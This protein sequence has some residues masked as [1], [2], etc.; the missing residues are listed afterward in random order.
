MA[1]RININEQRLLDWH[2]AQK[3]DIYLR[4][5]HPDSIGTNIPHY[6][7]T[8][9]EAA[10]MAMYDAMGNALAKDL[11]EGRSVGYKCGVH[12]RDP[13]FCNGLPRRPRGR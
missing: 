6:Q 1:H 2:E 10:D 7:I 9:D 11:G 4:Y 13:N 8:A 3:D 5:F 12:H